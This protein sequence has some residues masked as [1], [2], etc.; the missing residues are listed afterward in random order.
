MRLVTLNKS[1][2]IVRATALVLVA[3]AVV[4]S[5]LGG[6]TSG[7]THTLFGAGIAFCF[8]MLIVPTI[9]I[10]SSP[11]SLWRE[12][13]IVA[14]LGALGGLCLSLFLAAGARPVEIVGHMVFAGGGLAFVWGVRALRD[15]AVF[16][17]GR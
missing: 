16:A 10:A 3:L 9:F 8:M 6:R 11:I 2:R 1:P 15:Q 12:Y 17:W 4:L 5:A 14:L 13:L 7:Q